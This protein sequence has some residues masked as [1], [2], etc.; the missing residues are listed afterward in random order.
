VEL[1]GAD[2]EAS[3]GSGDDAENDQ[4]EYIFQN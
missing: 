1:E 4:D 2:S 3:D